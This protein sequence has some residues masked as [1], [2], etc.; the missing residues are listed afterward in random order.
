MTVVMVTV[1]M[2]TVVM[3]IV[4]VGV[5]RGDTRCQFSLIKLWCQRDFW[6]P[7]ENVYPKDN[8]SLLSYLYLT[9]T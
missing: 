8:T 4:G 9:L 2:V 1:V 6:F 3:V 7:I 5:S